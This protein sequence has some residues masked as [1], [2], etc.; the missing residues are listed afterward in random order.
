MWLIVYCMSIFYSLLREFY[1]FGRIFSFS[2]TGLWVP[3]SLGQA[4]CVFRVYYKT[5]HADKQNRY[6]MVPFCSC[7]SLRC[8]RQ[9]IKE[10]WQTHT[11][12]SQL[13]WELIQSKSAIS[14]TMHFHER[15]DFLFSN[16]YLYN[17]L[18]DLA[19]FWRR[20]DPL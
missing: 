12:K 4:L 10:L 8:S 9:W 19:S 5:T 3:F 1:Q 13:H 7:L 16:I 20:Q 17:I 18:W 11:K 14:N 6:T 15:G 2:E